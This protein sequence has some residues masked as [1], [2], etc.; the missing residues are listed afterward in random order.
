[1]FLMH[2]EVMLGMS[3]GVNVEWVELM[4]HI[5]LLDLY[6]WWELVS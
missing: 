4:V 6:C 3:F 5:A 2:V 1:M